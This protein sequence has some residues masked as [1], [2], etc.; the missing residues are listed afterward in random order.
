[1]RD[2]YAMHTSDTT[3]ASNKRKA[4]QRVA[5]SVFHYASITDMYMSQPDA[6]TLFTLPYY[7]DLTIHTRR[8]N[9]GPGGGES[10]GHDIE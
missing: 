3:A 1:M 2:M 9:M 4:I 7:L 6:V 5:S 10:R 8:N